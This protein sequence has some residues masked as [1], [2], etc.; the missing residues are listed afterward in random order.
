MMDT[1]ATKNDAVLW[2]PN[3]QLL[4]TTTSFRRSNAY[5]KKKLLLSKGEL[6]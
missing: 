5:Q 2:L 4:T 3:K 1:L 6:W